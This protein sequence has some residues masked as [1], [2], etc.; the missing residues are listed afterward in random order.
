MAEG[1]GEREGP[2]DQDRHGKHVGEV[3]RLRPEHLRYANTARGAS[4]ERELAP[5]F[6]NAAAGPCGPGGNEQGRSCAGG[7]DGGRQHPSPTPGSGQRHELGKEHGLPR[8]EGRSERA[9]PGQEGC[10]PGGPLGGN[11]QRERQ[12]QRRDRRVEHPAEDEEHGRAE[13]KDRAHGGRDGCDAAAAGD[14]VR[15]RDHRQRTEHGR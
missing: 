4:A 9:D 13:P 1:N 7:A 3:P 10:V 14:Y 2:Q 5:E 6:C 11:H 8:W 15:E 12:R